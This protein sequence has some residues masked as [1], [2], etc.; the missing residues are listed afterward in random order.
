MCCLLIAI[1]PTF[2]QQLFKGWARINVVAGAG[3]ADVTVGD[4]QLALGPGTTAVRTIGNIDLASGVRVIAPLSEDVLVPPA[5]TDVLVV[6]GQVGRIDGRAGAVVNVNRT[7][8]MDY[9]A[10]RGGELT[11]VGTTGP[12]LV[13]SGGRAQAFGAAFPARVSEA[14]VVL[15][16]GSVHLVNSI[17]TAGIG[18][19]LL[20]S[21]ESNGCGT[22]RFVFDHVAFVAASTSIPMVLDDVAE[23]ASLAD[24]ESCNFFGCFSA[25]QVQAVMSPATP[26]LAGTDPFVF[27]APPSAVIRNDGQCQPGVGGGYDVGP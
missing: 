15:L 6:G 3:I 14:A 25:T 2:L 9:F 18:E 5:A 8:A 7:R 20:G 23:P 10:A 13:E 4:F 22:S 11:L 16:S 26:T 19:I 21:C 1:T 27:G 17:V 12:L 24:F